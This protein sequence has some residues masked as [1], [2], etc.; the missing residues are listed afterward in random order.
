M[1]EIK[2]IKYFKASHGL[3]NFQGED[4]P[5]HEHHWRMEVVV[6]SE[7]VDV[8]GCAID[9]HEVDQAI[10]EVIRPYEGKAFNDVEPFIEISPSAELIAK[11]FYNR[12]AP[13]FNKQ[14]TALLSVTI[15]EDDYHRATYFT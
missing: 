4:E 10:A 8:S 3:Y 7:E 12:L 9:F 5:I 11:H 1:F 15:C 13:A 14:H 2:V 6:T